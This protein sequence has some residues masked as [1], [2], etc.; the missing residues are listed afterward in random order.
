MLLDIGDYSSTLPVRNDVDHHTG[1]NDREQQAIIGLDPTVSL[2]WP[3][4]VVSIVV[5]YPVV[6]RK[7][8]PRHAIASMPFMI[9]LAA[10]V[11][12]P[13]ALTDLAFTLV[14]LAREL[15][16]SSLT[17]LAGTLPRLPRLAF[18]LPR[19]AFEFLLLPNALLRSPLAFS[20]L[21]LVLLAIPLAR[22]ALLL[23]ALPILFLTALVILFLTLTFL[24]LTLTVLLLALTV[25]FLTPAVLFLPLAA[26]LIAQIFLP[27]LAVTAIRLIANLRPHQANG[28]DHQA[29]S[30]CRY[31][32]QF[33]AILSRSFEVTCFKIMH[34]RRIEL[35]C[36]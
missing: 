13:F 24:L 27:V 29:Y 31:G 9:T 20:I 25:L 32:N 3:P 26:L 36:G 17:F 7:V 6:P 34:H 2:R 1:R 23:L 35:S 14:L 33:H 19:L 10:I 4:Q 28:T 22:L 18:T 8:A 15:L 30:Q 11:L 5:F 12:L 16:L 21:T